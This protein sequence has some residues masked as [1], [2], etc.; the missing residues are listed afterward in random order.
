MFGRCFAVYFF[1]RCIASTLRILYAVLEIDERGDVARCENEVKK[2]SNSCF[3]ARE[4][5]SDIVFPGSRTGPG[6][7][8]QL[9][10]FS[11]RQEDIWATN[12]RVVR[13]GTAFIMSDCCLYVHISAKVNSRSCL[14]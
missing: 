11:R 7:R 10:D 14:E 8:E 4:L 3:N 6:H 9:S 2:A 13:S 1:L 12:M 5:L